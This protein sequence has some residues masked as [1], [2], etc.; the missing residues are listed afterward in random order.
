MGLY[1]YSTTRTAIGLTKTLMEIESIHPNT[2]T[3]TDHTTQLK[4]MLMEVDEWINVREHVPT[5]E[6]I[7]LGYQDEM[8]IGCV[9]G[10]NIEFG[11]SCTGD[12]ELLEGVTHWR[13]KPFTLREAKSVFN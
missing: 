1:V 8:L 10:P 12:S 4:S 5:G 2:V 7:A 9:H 6:V 13:P 3:F 11:W